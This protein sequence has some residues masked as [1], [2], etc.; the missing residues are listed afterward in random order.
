MEKKAFANLFLYKLRP[1]F[2]QIAQNVL[3]FLPGENNLILM[4]GIVLIGTANLLAKKSIYEFYT[5]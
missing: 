2:E 5:I 4:R 1:Q 3:V